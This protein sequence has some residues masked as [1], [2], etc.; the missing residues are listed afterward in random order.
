ALGV[1]L[2]LVRLVELAGP[3]AVFAE[4]AEHRAIGPAHEADLLVARI[5]H[6]HEALGLVGPEGDIADGAGPARLLVVDVFGDEGAVL[7]E[8]LHTVV[9]AI[10]HI[11]EPVL[12]DADAVD[13]AKLLRRG[14]ARIVRA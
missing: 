12:G 5:V 2:Y 13:D 1:E 10:R 8:D 14:R 4:G 11:D 9:Q 7:L 6:G 3:G